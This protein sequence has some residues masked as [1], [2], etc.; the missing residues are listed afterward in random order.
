MRIFC[1][2]Q[3]GSIC[4]FL[5]LI[6][7]PVLIFSGIIVDASRLFASKTV[8][9]GA[10]DLAMNAALAQYDEMLKDSYG[11]TAMA[12]DPGSPQE[13]E[14]L[15][16]MFCESISARYLKSSDS[17]DLSSVIQVALAENGFE[18]K[19]VSSSSLADVNVL[20]QQIV[21]YMKFRGPVY[22][23]DDIIEKL[24]KLPFKNVKKQK[25]Y[26][27]KKTEYGQA[28]SEL[29]KPMKKAKEAIDAQAAAIGQ[30]QNCDP[31]GMVSAYRQKSVFW[32]AAKS[33]QMYLDKDIT[34][35]FP[36]DTPDEI[37]YEMI[38]NYLDYSVILTEGTAEFPEDIYRK[39]ITLLA[40]DSWIEALELQPQTGKIVTEENGFSSEQ[41]NAYNNISKTIKNNI[42]VMNQSHEQAVK[43]YQ[44]GIKSLEKNAYGIISAGNEAVKQLKEVRK[45]WKKVE[46]KRQLYEEALTSLENAGEKPSE[47]KKE[48]NI[49]IDERE[50][51][52]QIALLEANTEA[53]KV[54][55]E[56]IKELKTIPENLK[57]QQVSANEGTWLELNPASDAIQGF[58]TSHNILGDVGVPETSGLQNPQGGLFYQSS[59]ENMKD[60]SAD[61]SEGKQRKE[62]QKEAKEK[63]KA[64]ND[65]KN[66]ILNAVKNERNLKKD[67]EGFPDRFPSGLAKVNASGN[68]YQDPDTNTSDDNAAVDAAK[69]NMGWLDQLA[70]CL[71]SLAG[72]VL[73]QAYLME[74]I[75]EMFNCMTTAIED[76]SLSGK[77]LLDNHV[78]KNGEIEYILYGNPSTATNKSIAYS[79]LYAARLSVDMLYVFMDKETNDAANVIAGAVSSASGQAWLYPIIK[80]GYLCCSAITMAAKE[81]VNLTSTDKKINAV[82][83]WPDEKVC[84]IKFTYKDYMKLFLLISMMDDSGKNK[85]VARAGDC[86]QLN[87]REELSSKY[88][89]VT[90]KADVDVSTTFLP[91]VPEFLGQSG[92]TDDG[93][94]RMKYR[95]VLAY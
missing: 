63:E 16:K 86:I 49:E 30:I 46:E 14:E 78:I 8:V 6:L 31:V 52:N 93:K 21:E 82:L 28:A 23:A 76:Q 56:N 85:L 60:E 81:T 13:Q 43:E 33:L 37:S 90:L 47:D 69:E 24:K 70:Y 83:V 2:K 58:W 67:A 59:L 25:N 7:V 68:S 44:T 41:I 5:T 66:K 84:S 73:E 51:E 79:S 10:G 26:V 61:T 64:A 94:R 18:A 48:E 32:L 53:A 50:L 75:S 91:K 62:H 9:S 65:A 95:S 77:S 22:I 88:T 38:G 19:G 11:L 20:R 57:K 89:M 40:L 74:Y 92:S 34:A 27:D 39:M 15:K 3:G 42:A 36:P 71:D 87:I 17:D 29:S 1:G 35:N 72:N 45:K 12:K 4:V 55:K 54:Y 80:Y